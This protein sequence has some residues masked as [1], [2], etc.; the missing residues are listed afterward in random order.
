MSIVEGG[1]TELTGEK[2]AGVRVSLGRSGGWG[3]RVQLPR[4]TIPNGI[5]KGSKSNLHRERNTRPKVLG[6]RETVVYSRATLW[7]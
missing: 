6:V 2:Y 3:L 7:L 4:R 1:R 5:L